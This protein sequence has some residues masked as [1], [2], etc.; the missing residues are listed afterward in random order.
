MIK[1]EQVYASYLY[2]GK[3]KDLHKA[4]NTN[5]DHELEEKSEN[6][7]TDG[8]QVD[9]SLDV[10]ISDI[11]KLNRDKKIEEIKTAIK[12]GMYKI[13]SKKLSEEILNELLS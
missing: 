7:D 11:D 13:N 10:D 5:K 9:I 6:I 2:G 3:K 1:I 4:S 8:I 12:N